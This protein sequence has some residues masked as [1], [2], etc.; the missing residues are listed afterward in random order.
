MN[1]P[2]P[3]SS[4]T[5]ST[6]VTSALKR[7]VTPSSV[8]PATCPPRL[9][10]RQGSCQDC[11]PGKSRV[12]SGEPGTRCEQVVAL[13]LALARARQAV[14]RPRSPVEPEL[15]ARRRRLA[16]RCEPDERVRPLLGRAQE[17]AE[18]A[19]EAGQGLADARRV[20]PAGMHR[21]HDDA[22][23]AQD[24]RPTPGRAPSRR[25][26]SARRRPD[27]RTAPRCSA[28]RRRRA[29]ACTCRPR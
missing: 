19:R 24:G 3:I 8:I 29:A 13:D 7:L 5:S 11:I 4:D 10:G 17:R 2:S 18:R 22:A 23:A 27:R 25:A 12:D 14:E 15:P 6:A 21:V 28:G 1:S 26:S 16:S 9:P 20:G